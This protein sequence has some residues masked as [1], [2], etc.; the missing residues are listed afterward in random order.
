MDFQAALD[1]LKEGKTVQR[2]K[3][4]AS[5]TLENDLLWLKGPDHEVVV[6]S[7]D[8]EDVLAEDWV[9]LV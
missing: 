6:A 3:A 2:S 1:C 8:A 4:K 5:Y 7:I 9:A